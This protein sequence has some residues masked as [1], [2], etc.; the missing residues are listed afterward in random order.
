[1]PLVRF[2]TQP[3]ARR[4]IAVALAVT[5]AGVMWARARGSSRAVSMPPPRTS[6]LAKAP[7]TTPVSPTAA[8]VDPWNAALLDF[9]SSDFGRVYRARAMFLA[10]PDRAVP[11]LLA[12]LDRR[13]V[14]ELFNT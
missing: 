11:A 6:P 4:L 8:G 7:T 2:V 13:D 5:A 14:M 9:A 1:M 12:M 10:D 3:Q